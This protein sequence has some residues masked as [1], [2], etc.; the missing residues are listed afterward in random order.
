MAGEA[1]VGLHCH[2]VIQHHGLIG[3]GGDEFVHPF[4]RH[5]DMAGGAGA[6]AAALGL[7]GQPI[8]ADDLHRPPARKAV[9][10]VLGAVIV[11]DVDGDVFHESV[12]SE[13][14]DNLQVGRHPGLVPG[15]PS[16]R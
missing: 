13:L 12:N 11:G 1:G 5:I 8:I 10:P 9:E 14:C 16:A 4:F 7:D 6:G 15:S 2:G 3:I